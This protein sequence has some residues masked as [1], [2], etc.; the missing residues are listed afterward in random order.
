MLSSINA[1]IS[2]IKYWLLRFHIRKINI[3]LY[4]VFQM[5]YYIILTLR[6]ILPYLYHVTA[7][8]RIW[9]CHTSGETGVFRRDAERQKEYVPCYQTCDFYKREYNRLLL[10]Q[11]WFV[12]VSTI[13]IIGTVLDMLWQR[14]NIQGTNFQAQYFLNID[15]FFKRVG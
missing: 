13:S 5:F 15:I 7:S 10:Q 8:L 4:I 11:L 6:C 1:Y 2:L 14:H 12:P 3:Y 9:A